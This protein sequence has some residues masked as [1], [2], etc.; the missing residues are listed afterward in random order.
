MKQEFGIEQR[1]KH[2]REAEEE[3]APQSTTVKQEF[4]IEQ[5]LKHPREVEEELA[6]KL[7]KSRT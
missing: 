4:A 6:A 2:P 3:L 7:V 1:L 5:R